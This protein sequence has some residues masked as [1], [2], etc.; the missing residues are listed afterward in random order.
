MRNL[1]VK[2]GLLLTVLILASAC[3]EDQIQKSLK[4]LDKTVKVMSLA[5]DTVI[6][7][8]RNGQIPA[9]TAKGLTQQFIKINEAV[10]EGAKTVEA[11]QL[12]DEPRK[13]EILTVLQPIL[14]AV[15]NLAKDQNILGIKDEK[16]RKSIQLA[17]ATAQATLTS[18]QTS[19]QLGG[20]Q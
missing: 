16:V 15:N 3:N 19:L 13:K 10:I 5:Q 18:I 14:T 8:Y 7:G 11:I 12:L 1:R 2:L 17:V 9:A 4:A 6:T 20:A